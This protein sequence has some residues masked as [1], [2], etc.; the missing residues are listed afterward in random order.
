MGGDLETRSP[1]EVEGPMSDQRSPKEAQL[2]RHLDRLL[3][4]WGRYPSVTR[5]VRK[6]DKTSTKLNYLRWLSWYFDWLATDYVVDGA[7]LRPA[8]RMDPDQLVRDNLEC[9]FG[10]RPQDVL[11]KRRHTDW[12][13][14]F[15]NDHMRRRGAG[16]VQ[17]GIAAAVRG[18]Y[19]RNDSELFGDFR[20][21]L[22]DPEERA[23]ALP[24]DDVRTV[25]KVLPLSVRLPAL[26]EWQSG[27]EMSRVLSLRW[28]KVLPG[29]GREGPL[30]LQFQ[31]RKKHRRA[32]HT[33]VGRDSVALLGVWREEWARLWGRDP[34]PEDLVFRG[35]QGTGTDYTWINKRVKEAAMQLAKRGMVSATSPASWHSHPLRASFETE[36]AHAGVP[37]E[38]RGFF[39]GHISDVMWVYNHGDQ[40][41]EEDLVKE[42]LKLEPYVS[43]E[44]NEAMVREQ[45]ERE[46]GKQLRDAQ[47]QIRDL[48]KENASLRE[49]LT[50]P[51]S[52]GPVPG[53]PGIF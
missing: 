50:P 33:Y 46:T 1:P 26:I 39:E 23:P 14:Q 21:S 15:V 40:L 10:S 44:P 51:T 45:V 20:V 12:L 13:D 18:F 38:V 16:S 47:A 32:Y 29:L 3:A 8:V 30:K 19:R 28:E 9:V 43:L 27:I 48:E 7:V 25:L 41:H 31:G 49:R 2:Q 5:F 42:Y 11:K 52:T 36:A 34:S 17:V 24:A 22:P 53:V 6:V 37:K 4:R 35:K